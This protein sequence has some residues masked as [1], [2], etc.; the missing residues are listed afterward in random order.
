MQKANFQTRSPIK[1]LLGWGSGRE[2]RN[3]LASL[4]KRCEGGQKEEFLYGQG[5][6]IGYNFVGEGSGKRGE[7]SCRIETYH[8]TYFLL[9]GEIR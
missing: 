8:S 5:L 3:A 2:S 7:T 6:L 4:A 1:R 9:G